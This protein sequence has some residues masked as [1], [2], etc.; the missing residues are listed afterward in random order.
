MILIL[1]LSDGKLNIIE[2]PRPITLTCFK[3]FMKYFMSSYVNL[4][5]HYLPNIQVLCVPCSELIQ[6]NWTVSKY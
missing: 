2:E 5:T 6:C 1:N 4:V 3:N